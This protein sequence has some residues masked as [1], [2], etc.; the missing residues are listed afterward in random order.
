MGL[1]MCVVERSLPPQ[2]SG[3]R[4]RRQ[5]EASILKRPVTSELWMP[6]EQLE[7]WEVRLFADRYRPQLLNITLRTYQIV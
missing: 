6:E 4:E 5:P 3:L 2:R 7:L 1:C